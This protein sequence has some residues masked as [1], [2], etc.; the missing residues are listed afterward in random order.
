MVASSC[1]SKESASELILRELCLGARSACLEAASGGSC[2]TAEGGRGG[3]LRCSRAGPHSRALET[4]RSDSRRAAIFALNGTSGRRADLGVIYP[5]PPRFRRA[6]SNQRTDVRWFC[7]HGS[8]L[9]DIYRSS[10]LKHLKISTCNTPSTSS[11]VLD[12]TSSTSLSL[13][14]SLSQHPA[15]LNLSQQIT[16]LSA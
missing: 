5:P 11:R 1:S 13:S 15:T 2:G 16:A 7:T 3:V 6:S 8:R 12:L 4:T 9:G 14:L 10:D